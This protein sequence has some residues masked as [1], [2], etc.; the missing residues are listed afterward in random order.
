MTDP[1]TDDVVFLLT[2]D[3]FFSDSYLVGLTNQAWATEVPRALAKASFGSTKQFYCIDSTQTASS[4]LVTDAW[5]VCVYVGNLGGSGKMGTATISGPTLTLTTNVLTDTTYATSGIEAFTPPTGGKYQFKG[6][7]AGTTEKKYVGMVC[8]GVAPMFYTT[9]WNTFA[10][11][12]GSGWMVT[13]MTGISQ[14][15]TSLADGTTAL[16]TSENTSCLA[17]P[18]YMTWRMVTHRIE[19]DGTQLWYRT[20]SYWNSASNIACSTWG[21]GIKLSANHASAD[22]N[23]GSTTALYVGRTFVFTYSDGSGVQLNH[24]S[25]NVVAPATNTTAGTGTNALTAAATSFANSGATIYTNNNCAASNLLLE[26]T[27][28]TSGLASAVTAYSDGYKATVTVG[29]E[30]Q[31]N[32]A[33]GGWSGVCMVLYS[34][35]Y[36]QDN[37]NGAVC[38]AA[39]QNSAAGSGPTDFGGVLLM[40]VP[41]ATWAPPAASGPVTPSGQAIS[42]AKYGI[43]YAPTAATSYLFTEGY[44]ASATWYQPSYASSYTLVARYGKDNYVGSYCMSGSGNTSYFSAPAAGKLFTGAATLAASVLA[45]GAATLAML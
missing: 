41:A 43:V 27:T 36:I 5:D 39:T 3:E 28:D 10:T 13:C 23:N 15:G 29:L 24:L 38:V 45:A 30:A 4:N 31:L 33:L 25:Y 11:Q 12:A 40:H 17:D 8:N 22:D 21:P 1:N 16:S 18:R 20:D 37:T 2:S 19:Y 7:T 44:Y 9:A 26:G 42:D 32:G 6:L 34:S 14:C 35:Q